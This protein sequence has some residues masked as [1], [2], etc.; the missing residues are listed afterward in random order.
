MPSI[1][2]VVGQ[3]E[4]KV[5]YETRP[6]S[7]LRCCPKTARAFSLRQWEANVRGDLFAKRRDVVPEA[8]SEGAMGRAWAPEEDASLP[9]EDL[10]ELLA[11]L[12]AGEIDG[13]EEEEVQ[14]SP[15]PAASKASLSDAPAASPPHICIKRRRCGG[16]EQI[17]SVALDL[18][19][20]RRSGVVFSV[21]SWSVWVRIKRFRKPHAH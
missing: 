14:G 8:P 6:R 18:A 21:A 10:V 1:T 5:G 19:S 16:Y 3:P 4:G 2:A 13:E 17:C 15:P 11:V 9:E 12:E 20:I 7:G